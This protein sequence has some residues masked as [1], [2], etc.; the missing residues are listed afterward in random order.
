MRISLPSN[1]ARIH[2]WQHL[3]TLRATLARHRHDLAFW[4]L[5]YLVLA[6]ALFAVLFKSIGVMPALQASV[7][8]I[9]AGTLPGAALVPR[10]FP[11]P[12]ILHYVIV[13]TVIG[14]GLWSLGGM[15]S[16]ITGLFWVR[17]IPT[18]AGLA[19]WLIPR[20][21]L[22]NGE[23]PNARSFPTLG[24]VGSG[25]G[26]VALLPSIRTVLLSQPTQW[27]GWHHFYV[28]LPF[29][30]AL[31]GEV[32]AH[33]PQV[34]PWVVGTPLSYTWLYHSSM[35]VWASITNVSAADVV[36]QVWPVLFAVLIP[37]L[38]SIAA[39]EVTRNKYV[40]LAAPL[41]YVLSHGLIFAARLVGQIPLFQISPTRDFASLFILLCVLSLVRL[42][43]NSSLRA[44]NAWW[45]LMLGISTFVL[46]GAKGSAMPI[47]LGGVLCSV[48]FLIIVRRLRVIDL[49]VAGEFVVVAVASFLLTLPAPGSTR[50]LAWGPLAFS[51]T[52]VTPLA[53]VSLLA[54]L[55]FATLSAWLVIGIHTPNS[56]LVS[57]LL[58]GVVLAGLLGLG[59]LTHP[60]S[61]EL[62][63]WESAQPLFAIFLTWASVILIGRY[64][65]KFALAV[66]SIWL[67]SNVLSGAAPRMG[68]VGAAVVV[69]ALCAM[70]ILKI[71]THGALAL[72]QQRPWYVRAGVALA[73]AGVL[74]QSAQLVNIP[75]GY[76]GGSTTNV[77]DPGAINETQLAAFQFIRS[78]ST[79]AEKVITNKHCLSGTVAD[80]N[81]DARWFAV[82]AWTERRV[83][84]EGWAYTQ[85]GTS[86]DWVQAELDLGDHFISSP[87]LADKLKLLSLGVKYVYVD[88]RDAYSTN[89]SSVSKQVYTSEW[90]NVYSLK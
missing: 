65:K 1:P 70:L 86:P 30:I 24:V 17:W 10:L 32:A 88:K 39:W 76:A 22:D 49:L 16:H 63:F 60:T 64:G 73:I 12:S 33:A 18:V 7:S 31:T 80:Q 89:L 13:G 46:T 57:S 3:D 14:L 38:I 21:R 6:T 54:I 41:V 62:Y 58:G 28:D 52:A 44:T 48:F 27:T 2:R 35:G 67:V 71:S 11:R 83:L 34:Y 9:L 56:W 51:G 82:A 75:T 37:L 47:V 79:P 69:M 81:C 5:A 72:G 78:H 4:T 84:V 59:L 19:V 20:R 87:T 15:L 42:L 53:A 26:L 66:F 40:A 29:Q 74:T 68:V 85:N 77:N 55:I 50:S 61:S 43:G 8:L 36:L 25:L 45:F 90:A 23:V